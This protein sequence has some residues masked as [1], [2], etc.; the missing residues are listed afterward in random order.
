MSTL[1]PGKYQLKSLHEEIDLFDRKLAHLLKY[2]AFPSD[3]ER[4]AAAGKLAAKRDLLVRKARQMADDGIEFSQSELPKSLRQEKTVETAHVPLTNGSTEP[5]GEPI[6]LVAPPE[7]K[8]PS[9]Y[10]GTALDCEPELAAYKKT[11]AK[12]K[13]A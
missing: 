2:E 4:N 12:R 10:A 13:T 6:S 8:Q 3:S 5:T 7:Q 11:K 9:P 1:P